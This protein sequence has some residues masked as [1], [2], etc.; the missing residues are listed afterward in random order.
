[1]ERIEKWR[2]RTRWFA[3]EFLVVVTGVLVAL[4]INAWWEARREHGLERG[5]LL[6]L[7]ADLVADSLELEANL[8]FERKRAEQAR[9]LIRSLSGTRPDDTDAFIHAVEEVAWVLAPRLSPYTFQELQSTGNLRLLRDPDI[10]R[11]LSAYYYQSIN[12]RDFFLE[13]AS[14]RAWTYARATS[15]VLPSE[16]R[17]AISLEQPADTTSTAAILARLAAIPEARAM[18][19]EVLVSTTNLEWNI[20][21]TQKL[22]SEALARVRSG[23]DD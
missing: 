17:V 1:M 14:D 23:L 15:G 13:Y 4:A 19:S 22:L 6:R 5:Y 3:A 16:T 2:A 21:S 11:A 20:I 12:N 7:E 8:A 18:V 9:L 10:R